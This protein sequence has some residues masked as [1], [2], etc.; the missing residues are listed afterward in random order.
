MPALRT[1]VLSTSSTLA[2]VFATAGCGTPPT[3]GPSGPPD[4][5]S[6]W[7]AGTGNSQAAVT[8]DGLWQNTVCPTWNQVLS[9]VPGTEANWTLTPNVLRVDNRGAMFCG[10]VELL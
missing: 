5:R 3:M 10:Q 4:F 7:S 6:D 9:V 1:R 8:D 2:L